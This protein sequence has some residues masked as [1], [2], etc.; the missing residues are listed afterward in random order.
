MDPLDRKMFSPNPYLTQGSEFGEMYFPPAVTREF[1]YQEDGGVN[2]VE[3][4]KEGNI[5]V[6][7]PVDLTLSETRNPAEALQR[8]RNKTNLD[9]LQTGIMAL[10]F[11]RAPGAIFNLGKAALQPLLKRLPAIP[12]LTIRQSQLLS[13]PGAKGQF[14]S[15]NPNQI[16][17]LTDAG[18]NVA[19]GT[20]AVA[21]VTAL[22]A[23]KPGPVD[24]SADLAALNATKPKDSKLKPMGET[25][26][27]KKEEPKGPPIVG[28][29]D[30]PLVSKVISSPDFNRFINNLATQLTDTGSRALGG[31]KG[32]AEAFDEKLEGINNVVSIET[33][34]AERNRKVNQEIL[35]NINEFEQTERNLSRLDYAISLVD[36]GATGLAGLFGKGWTDFLALFNNNSDTPFGEL[37][38]RTQADRILTAL[39]Q[40]DIRNILGE[41]GRTISNLDREIVA[42]IF[43]SIK[44]TSTPAEIKEA[45]RE[46]GLRYRK[47]LKRNRNEILAGIDYF[48]QTGMPSSVLE[49]NVGGLST[50]LSI[51]DFDNYKAPTYDPGSEGYGEYVG[52]NITDIEYV[53]GT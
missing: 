49:G 19:L 34:D 10:P 45:L 2:Y 36:E 12:Q 27:T 40:Q 3:K 4:D 35:G 39:R 22:E 5:L 26:G 6:N 24:I 33:S 13:G 11:L 15:T 8:Q 25:L 21:G 28:F 23:A 20:G 47:G 29:K 42:E 31:A 14:R 41:S 1:V 37:D 16:V 53:E 32:A 30:Q 50:I 43:G 46:I 44:V 17:G 18:K 9:R 7:E 48:N 52:G 51:Q 38:P